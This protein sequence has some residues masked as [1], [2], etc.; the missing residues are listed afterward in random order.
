MRQLAW[1]QRASGLA[2]EVIDADRPGWLRDTLGSVPES[3]RRK[4]AWRQAAG[5]L[6]Q[7]RATYD[8][9]DPDR[10]LGPA[11]RDLAQRGDWQ[12]ARAAVERVHHKQR[13]AERARAP[14]PTRAQPSAP[15]NQ[16]S[17]RARLAPERAAPPGRPGPERAAG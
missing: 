15:S 2:H 16:P 1:Q 5:Q 9:H 13:V 12:R 7:Y 14:Q 8:L 3:T 17:S 11:P 6:E 4:W 10:A